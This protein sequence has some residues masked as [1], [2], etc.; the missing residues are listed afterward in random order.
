[1]FAIIYLLNQE[2]Q[3]DL[4]HD[5]TYWVVEEDGISQRI[6][7]IEPFGP[8][9]PSSESSESIEVSEGQSIKGEHA[10]L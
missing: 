10:Y 2:K 5:K 4:Y 7:K 9:A 6:V 1:M 8:V 3:E